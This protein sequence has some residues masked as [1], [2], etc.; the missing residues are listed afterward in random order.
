MQLTFK[1]SNKSSLFNDSAEY[2]SQLLF[3]SLKHEL[4]TIE[5]NKVALNGDDDKRITCEDG[6][7]TLAG[8]YKGCKV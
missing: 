8:G 3:R 2:R 7:S 6:I 4:R 5:V 1:Y